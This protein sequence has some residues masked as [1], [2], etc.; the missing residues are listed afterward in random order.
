M[1]METSRGD[2]S[3]RLFSLLG[4]EAMDVGRTERDRGWD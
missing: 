3:R 4:K 2:W 1:N